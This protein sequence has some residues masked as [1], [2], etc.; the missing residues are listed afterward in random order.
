MEILTL[1]ELQCI[2]QQFDIPVTLR[3]SYTRNG[4]TYERSV[5][6][7]K[8]E[9]IQSFL[10]I[11]KEELKAKEEKMISE[12]VISR[13]AAPAKRSTKR[14]APALPRPNLMLQQQK[15][16]SSPTQQFQLKGPV[17]V[18]L[19]QSDEYIPHSILLFG[20]QH[21]NTHTNCAPNV[22]TIELT[23]YLEEIFSTFTDFTFDLF[24]EKDYV[25]REEEKVDRATD[26]YLT[27]VYKKFE[28]YLQLSKASKSQCKFKNLH[29]HYADARQLIP[30]R[31]H[32]NDNL[33]MYNLL[34]SPVELK[35]SLVDDMQRAY[36]KVEKQVNKISDK[37]V[38]SILRQD[39]YSVQSAL[40]TA[41]D[42]SKIY[43]ARAL[44]LGFSKFTEDCNLNCK[45]Q[46]LGDL[47]FD[48]RMFAFNTIFMQFV[49][50]MDIYLLGRMFGLRDCVQSNRVENCSARNIKMAVIYAGDLH[51]DN[52]VKF[53]KVLDYQ[54]KFSTK[55]ISDPKQGE[56]GFQCPSITELNLQLLS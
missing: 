53:L 13:R 9:L 12:P 40:K 27:P 33:E 37:Y 4:K 52:Y 28:C 17:T 30:L 45:N 11:A 23:D 26:N 20:D 43:Q 10:E 7:T 48:L 21:T 38:Q 1:K 31:G 16:L 54:V 18:T 44:E 47:Y 41:A 50:I 55:A 6:M 22:V 42:R 15:Q 14:Q 34:I 19:L 51:I 49:K 29:A 5:R 2:A 32:L 8:K 3:K 39:L 56:T 46:K 36:D 24:L 25:K 35:K